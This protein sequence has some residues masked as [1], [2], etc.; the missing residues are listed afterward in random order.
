MLITEV[1][2]LVLYHSPYTNT[3]KHRI[4]QNL[5]SQTLYTTNPRLNNKNKTYQKTCMCYVSNQSCLEF[6]VSNIWLHCIK[7]V[8]EITRNIVL[9]RNCY[10]KHI[11]V[12]DRTKY[13]LAC[14]SGSLIQKILSYRIFFDCL[15]S[16]IFIIHTS[17]INWSIEHLIMFR[18]FN[19]FQSCY[20]FK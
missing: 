15:T 6:V 10:L 2:I 11:L 9:Y 1:N 7:F 16:N 14:Y 4:Q 13:F 8:K 17:I 5:V 18:M 3:D 19:H 12:L 20:I